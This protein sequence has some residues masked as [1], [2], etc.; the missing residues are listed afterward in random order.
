MPV[1]VSIAVRLLQLTRIVLNNQ[2]CAKNTAAFDLCY[3]SRIQPPLLTI[4]HINRDTGYL[5]D[6]VHR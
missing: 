5:N 6:T 4:P 1:N 2:N 3:F